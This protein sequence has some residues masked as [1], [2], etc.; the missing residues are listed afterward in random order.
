MLCVG[1]V[2]IGPLRQRFWALATSD[3]RVRGSTALLG[4][5]GVRITGSE[6]AIDGD[7]DGV[8]ARF[9]V[10]EQPGVETL[11]PHGRSYIWT[12]KQGGVRV[13]GLLELDGRPLQLECR[14]IVDD[15][16]GYHARHTA[17]KWSAGVGAAGDGRRV[18]WNLITGVH[19][20]PRASERTVWTSGEPS[21]VGPVEFEPGLSAIRIGDGGELRFAEWG[22][23]EDN[24]NA[25]LLRNRY[26]QPFGTFAGT[27]PGG[28]ELSEGY[29][30]MESHDVWW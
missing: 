21:E 17:W 4:S 11:S 5:G 3:G 14:G 9:R 20:D 18:A 6:V 10:D 12:R 8:R 24:T 26:R 7:G 13:H 22:A 23:R 15:S 1:D 2:R 30:V 19:D 29:G 25:L 16:A 27:L 28:L